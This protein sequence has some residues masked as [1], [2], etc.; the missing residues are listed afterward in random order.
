MPKDI[1]LT[2]GDIELLREACSARGGVVRVDPGLDIQRRL[3]RTANAMHLAKLGYL[4]PIEDG[5]RIKPEL[6]R[7]VAEVLKGR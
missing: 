6:K 7:Q 5:W 4:E 1:V 3:G 2:E